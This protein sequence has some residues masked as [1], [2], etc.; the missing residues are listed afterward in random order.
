MPRSMR[1]DALVTI[2]RAAKSLLRP[3]LNTER[4]G[5]RLR[6]CGVHSV[7]PGE[8]LPQ[9]LRATVAAVYLFPSSAPACVAHRR[10]SG[11]TQMRHIL[12]PGE[13]LLRTRECRD[14][15]ALSI[16]P[17]RSRDLSVGATNILTRRVAFFEEADA[18]EDATAPLAFVFLLT[19]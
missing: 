8:L 13:T 2:V 12:Q 19:P 5:T 7:S 6:L 11:R 18:A 17:L 16:A 4:V 3:G 14:E 15:W 10:L 1:A 9:A